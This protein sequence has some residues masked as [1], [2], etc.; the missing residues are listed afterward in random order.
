[1]DMQFGICVRTSFYYDAKGRGRI[2]A[3]H[4]RDRMTTWKVVDERAMSSSDHQPVLQAWIDKF[5]NNLDYLR[6]TFKVVAR[7][8]DH[9]GYY[10]ILVP[11]S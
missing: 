6:S 9:E 8:C 2:K 11:A 4:K 10:F 7:G 1:M 5:T 3:V